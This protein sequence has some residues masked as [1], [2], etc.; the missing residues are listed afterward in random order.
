ME[1]TETVGWPWNGC[2]SDVL[3]FTAVDLVEED[4][5]G[6]SSVVIL[7]VLATTVLVAVRWVLVVLVEFVVWV[8]VVEITT[9]DNRFAL[10]WWTSLLFSFDSSFGLLKSCTSPF[11]LLGFDRCSG[12]FFEPVLE[13]RFSC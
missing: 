1:G 5:L 9:L 13:C 7:H 3:P 12:V 8:Q 10:F 11:L 4:I 6:L 2:T